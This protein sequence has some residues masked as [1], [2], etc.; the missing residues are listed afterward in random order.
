MARPDTS[1]PDVTVPV[2]GGE[3][4]RVT[5]QGEAILAVMIATTA[6]VAILVLAPPP[7]DASAHL[8]RTWLVDHGVLFWD[9]LWFAGSYPI[10]TYSPLYY[11]LAA[12]FGNTVL[13]VVGGVVAAMCFAVLAVSEWGAAGAWPAR[14]FGLCAAGPL[15]TGTAPY[16]LGLASALASLLALQRGRRAIALVLAGMTLAFSALAFFFLGLTLT[17][18]VLSRRCERRPLVVMGA[19]MATLAGCWAALWMFF[20]MAGRYPFAWWTLLS[21]AGVCCCGFALAIRAP[22]AHVMAAFF[23]LWLLSCIALYLV[24]NP[25]GEIVTR[26]RYVVFPLVLLTVLLGGSRPRWL[27]ALTLAGSATYNVVPYTASLAVRVAGDG[28]AA[29]QEYWQPTIDFLTANRSA[30]HVV[31][32]VATGGHW[33]AYHLPKAG[34]PVLRGWYRQVDMT[35]NEVLYDPSAEPADYVRWLHDNAVRYVVLPDVRLDPHTGGREAALVRHP[36]TGLT[37]VLRTD[38]VVIYEVP[39]ATELLS[40]LGDAR[41][42]RLMHDEVHGSV[43]AAGPYLLRLGWSP[44]WS[45]LEGAVTLQKTTDGRVLV[46]AERSG[47]FRIAVEPRSILPV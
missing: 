23:A 17:A 21:V 35:R 28:D 36:A 41:I 22:R 10:L 2:Q 29:Q 1:P 19:G 4:A 14:V 40:G 18:V 6:S 9:N 27:A 46:V 39:H 33:E 32:V 31:T 11:F 7:G 37:P 26:L 30:D 15:I 3:I 43:D 8:Y 34:I 5:V 20:P 13:M 12:L 25:M 38:D 16:G 44:H 42:A 24:P 47:A 45:V